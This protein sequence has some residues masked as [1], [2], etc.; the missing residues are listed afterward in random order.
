MLFPNLR[1]CFNKFD[2][3]TFELLVGGKDIYAFKN[4]IAERHSPDEI[5]QFL[6]SVLFEHQIRIDG[7]ILQLLSLIC[8]E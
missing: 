2:T 4:A 1:W 8:R 3:F 6:R 5:F 7:A